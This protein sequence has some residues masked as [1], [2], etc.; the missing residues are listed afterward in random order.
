[1]SDYITTMNAA[2]EQHLPLDI[3][4]KAKQFTIPIEF[5]QKMSELVVLIISSKSMT[6][7]T[8]KQSWFNLLPLMTDDQIAKLYDILR[9][10]K[11]KL[12]EIE[13]R[14]EEKKL[15]I[16]KKYLMKW[17]NMGYIK[18]MEDLKAAEASS[19]AADEQEADA[20]LASL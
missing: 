10:E 8:E 7:A 1:M 9:K 18:K 14:Y 6:E 15:E 12:D 16:K 2:I 11:Q 20:L 4:E 19:Q 3:Q 5:I 13:K 17:Q